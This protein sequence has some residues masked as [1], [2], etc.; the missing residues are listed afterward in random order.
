MNDKEAVHPND[1]LTDDNYS[2]IEGHENQHE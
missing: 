1:D 2:N